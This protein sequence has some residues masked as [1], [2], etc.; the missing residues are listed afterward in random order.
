MVIS[1]CDESEWERERKQCK[2]RNQEEKLDKS[3]EI[4]MEAIEFESDGYIIKIEIM[5]SIGEKKT[6]VTTTIFQMDVNI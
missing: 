3:N 1:Y 2:P 5:L 4:N 6:T